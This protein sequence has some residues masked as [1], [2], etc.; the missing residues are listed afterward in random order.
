VLTY[1]LCELLNHGAFVINFVL[2]VL[3]QAGEFWYVKVRTAAP[4]GVTHTTRE[5]TLA[6]ACPL[7]PPAPTRSAS[8]PALTHSRTST[9][10]ERP[11]AGGAALLELHERERRER[12]AV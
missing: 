7:V 1:L 4:C 9:E 12:V 2:V 8:P 11:Q 6:P 5:Q 3:L 10:R